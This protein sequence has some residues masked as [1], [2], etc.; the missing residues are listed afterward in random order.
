M[1]ACSIKRNIN[2][3]R[4]SLSSNL[5]VWT[6]TAFQ[7][8][9]QQRNFHFYKTIQGLGIL[10]S[11]ASGHLP[12]SFSFV[13]SGGDVTAETALKPGYTSLVNNPYPQCTS[14]RLITLLPPGPFCFSMTILGSATKGLPF[15]VCCTKVTYGK[16]REGGPSWQRVQ[17]CAP[18]IRVMEV[19]NIMY[20][21]YGTS[22]GFS[23]HHCG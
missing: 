7:W 19:L 12:L 2:I 21:D 16:E 18:N 22:E 20:V 17:T 9:L 5:F 3:S 14:W 11:F 1:H 13:P 8:W 6:R 4:S 15:A 10:A 23:Q